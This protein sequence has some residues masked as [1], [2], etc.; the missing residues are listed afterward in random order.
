MI[1]AGTYPRLS[2][3]CAIVIKQHNTICQLTNTQTLFRTVQ[4]NTKISNVHNVC[5]VAELEA[6]TEQL[7]QLFK[8]YCQLDDTIT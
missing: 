8:N 1:T 5:Q 3:R 6:Q 2:H 4:Y 7:I